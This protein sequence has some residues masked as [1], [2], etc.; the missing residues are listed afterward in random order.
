M[1]SAAWG[2]TDIAEMHKDSTVSVVWKRTKIRHLS[3]HDIFV[4]E[5]SQIFTSLQKYFEL[6]AFS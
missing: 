6:N 2:G 5:H 4:K 3:K 1:R